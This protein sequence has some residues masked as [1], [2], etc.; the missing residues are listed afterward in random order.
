MTDAPRRIVLTGVSRGLGRAMAEGFIARGRV[1]LGCARSA[2]PIADWKKRHGRSFWWAINVGDGDGKY[3]TEKWPNDV[4]K[5]YG[6]LKK[7]LKDEDDIGAILPLDQGV[8]VDIV[9]TPGNESGTGFPEYNVEVVMEKLEGGLKRIKLAPLAPEAAD[10]AEKS[11]W[12]LNDPGI[13][14]LTREQVKQLAAS[15]DAPAV[16]RGIFAQSTKSKPAPTKAAEPEPEPMPSSRPE[17]T[18]EPV[19]DASLAVESEDDRIVREAEQAIAAA[20]ARRAAAKKADVTP[21][22]SVPAPVETKTEPK[23]TPAPAKA[24]APKTEA[25]DD[26]AFYKEYGLED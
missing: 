11:C 19:K 8:W 25:E 18:P 3:F 7:K 26:A 2:D 24:A 23:P 1:V 21:S 14:T 15:G 22:T 10:E 4:K 5:Q 16:L 17:P 13:I 6:V 20:Q 9:K 12:D